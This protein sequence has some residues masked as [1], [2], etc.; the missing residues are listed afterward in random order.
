MSGL[1]PEAIIGRH[2]LEITR[3]RFCIVR[4]IR[5]DN[6]KIADLGTKCAFPFV[7]V[8]SEIERGNGKGQRQ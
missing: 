8:R 2:D 1:V 5:S 3:G 6:L 4:R 7:S